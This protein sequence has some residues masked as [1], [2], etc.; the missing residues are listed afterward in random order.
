V[1][2]Q[3]LPVVD[4]LSGAAPRFLRRLGLRVLRN[5]A[6]L[7]SASMV[8][9]VAVAAIF[10][11]LKPPVAMEDPEAIVGALIGA[12]ATLMLVF[13]AVVELSRISRTASADLILRLTTRF[14]EPSTR[15]L[16]AL[17]EG[18][19]LLFVEHDP[20]W[21]SYFL[22]DQQKVIGS[23]LHD[24]LKAQLLTR[25]AYSCQE[26]DD[27]L[28][29]FEDLNDLHVHKTLDLRLIWSAFD[30][31]LST[32]WENEA[33]QAYI[34]TQSDQ[35]DSEGAFDGFRNLVRKCDQYDDDK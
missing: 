8:L 13:M 23:G 21:D 30:Y 24:E 29:Q 25:R 18:E 34:K 27:F 31:Y 19:Y 32:V 28:G 1:N 15:I 10:L 35:S 3:P 6:P 16:M 11:Y 9:V 4:L 14:F 20:I 17:I 7:I 12:A 22:V 26:I 5:F 2:I 33:I